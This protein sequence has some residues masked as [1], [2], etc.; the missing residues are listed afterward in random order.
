M[1]F[2]KFVSENLK[3]TGMTIGSRLHRASSPYGW[4][5]KDKN[6]NRRNHVSNGQPF[7][8]KLAHFHE[9]K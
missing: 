7:E 6:T 1:F 2:T 8:Y 4:N 5:R 9:T 3:T